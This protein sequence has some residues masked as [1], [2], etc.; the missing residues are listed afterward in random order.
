MTPADFIPLET[1]ARRR[2]RRRRSSGEMRIYF[3]SAGGRIKIGSSVNPEVRVADIQSILP[4]PLTVIA[5]VPGTRAFERAIH[6]RLKHKRTRGEW[7][8]DCDEVRRSISSIVEMGPSAIGLGAMPESQPREIGA[9]KACSQDGAVVSLARLLHPMSRRAIDRLAAEAGVSPRIALRAASA[10]A[11]SADNYFRLCCAMGFDP[12]TR[13]RDEPRPVGRFDADML[14]L[15]MRL[16]RRLYGHTMRQAASSM[17]SS[18]SG[19]C[20]LESGLQVSI[21]TIINACFY[22]GVHP[23]DYL[24]M[25]PVSRETGH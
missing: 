14:S 11:V 23:F 18:A 24:V 20:R 16:A 3:I 6:R 8:I 10:I 22:I 1:N 17:H 15:G 4:D 21:S 12:V 25:A 7:F 19:V 2:H 5:I 9:P 13:M